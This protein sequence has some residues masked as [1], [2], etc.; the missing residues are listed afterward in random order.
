MSELSITSKRIKQEMEE[1]GYKRNVDFAKDLEK[2]FNDT[3]Y[4]PI[5]IS[6]WLNRDKDNTDGNFTLEELIDLSDFFGCSL[7]YLLGKSTKK[8]SDIE[9]IDIS[10][11]TGLSED[12]IKYL[13]NLMN[14]RLEKNNESTYENAKLINTIDYL[15][16]NEMG[17][18]VLKRIGDFLFYLPI[19]NEIQIIDS[20]DYYSEEKKESIDVEEISECKINRICESLRK[21]KNN[22][23]E[24]ECM[25]LEKKDFI[26][27]EIKDYKEQINNNSEYFENVYVYDK[28]LRIKANSEEIEQLIYEDEQK[29]EDINNQIELFERQRNHKQKGTKKKGTK[30]NAKK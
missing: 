4:N 28:H 16:N 5:R 23:N 29:L 6:R 9:N 18:S 17:K 26:E 22:T 8:E 3:R 30:N 14:S 25:L 12:S 11:I 1:R 2:R 24:F 27:D 13:K 19:M 20:D 15:L 7:D 21:L 10:R